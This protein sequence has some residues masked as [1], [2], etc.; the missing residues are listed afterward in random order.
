[1]QQSNEKPTDAP[2]PWDST[3]GSLESRAAARIM[4]QHAKDRRERIEIVSCT[5]RPRQDNSRPHATPWTETPDGP[6]FRMLYVP[7]GMAEDEARRI[8]DKPTT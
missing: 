3:V 4:L 5:P 7:P 2:R 1:M 8:V 6:L